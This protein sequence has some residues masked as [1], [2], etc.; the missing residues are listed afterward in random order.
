M[1]VDRESRAGTAAESGTRP[2]VARKAGEDEI[3][4]RPNSGRGVGRRRKGQGIDCVF[5]GNGCHVADRDNIPARA[6][7][8]VRKNAGGAEK[9]GPVGPERQGKIT[10]ARKINALPKIAYSVYRQRVGG[11]PRWEDLKK[12]ERSAWEAS[13]SEVEKE[14]VKGLAA[15]ASRMWQELEPDAQTQQQQKNRARKAG[16]R[17]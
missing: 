2:V 6:G 10:M 11:L 8:G 4:K 9:T 3:H 13:V 14:I 1:R 12:F 17:R 15:A 5:R 16:W 7:C